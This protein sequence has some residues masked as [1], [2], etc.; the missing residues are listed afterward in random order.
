[1]QNMLR[2]LVEAAG[3]RVIDDGEE[4]TADVVIAS[5]GEEPP[6]DTADRVIWLRTDPEADGK[7]DQSIYRYDRAGLLMAL[8]SASS[9][10]GK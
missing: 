3:Y 7:K 4:E 2:P 10:R 8:K 9:G 1:M 5:V 6:Q